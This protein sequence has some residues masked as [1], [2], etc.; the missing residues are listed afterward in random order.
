MQSCVLQIHTRNGIWLAVYTIHTFSWPPIYRYIHTH[1]MCMYIQAI[2]INPHTREV[3]GGG[4][5]MEDL[6]P[7]TLFHDAWTTE[8]LSKA[9]SDPL[10]HLQTRT[11]TYSSSQS[12]LWCER[13]I[14]YC[15]SNLTLSY[16]IATCTCM[17]AKLLYSYLPKTSTSTTCTIQAHTTLIIDNVYPLM[18]VAM[19]CTIIAA[20]Q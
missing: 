5:T 2:G 20:E 1:I 15:P 17:Y 10:W 16:L 3:A 11:N 6:T 8:Y 18:S 12:M 7:F 19:L 14:V 4:L 9:H 13:T